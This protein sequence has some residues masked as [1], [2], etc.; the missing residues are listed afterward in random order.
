MA[1]AAPKQ[2]THAPN[3]PIR[4]DKLAYFANG[5]EIRLTG[6]CMYA[7][8]DGHGTKRQIEK[9]NLHSDS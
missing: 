6:F 5:I 4:N 9:E 3:T 1:E 7:F 2:K 8:I